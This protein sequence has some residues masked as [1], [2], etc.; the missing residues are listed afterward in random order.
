MVILNAS[1]QRSTPYREFRRR[2]TTNVKSR[3]TSR[4]V[5]HTAPLKTLHVPKV[6]QSQHIHFRWRGE[7][8]RIAG[9]TIAVVPCAIGIRVHLTIRHEGT[10]VVDVHHTV[11]VAISLAVPSG[12]SKEDVPH[13][14]A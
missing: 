3:R 8:A 5:R 9:N 10:V 14:A 12:T 6:P 2:P 11:E 1:L 4:F 13:L 7:D